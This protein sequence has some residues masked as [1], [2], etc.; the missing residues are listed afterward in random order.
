MLPAALAALAG[1]RFEPV[2]VVPVDGAPP[3]PDVSVDAPPPDANPDRDMDTILDEVDNC[4]NVANT[5]QDDCDGDD[6]GDACD[7]KADGPDADGDM[8]S[9]VCDNCP[10]VDN[11]DQ[12]DVRDA[13]EVG[14][15]CDPQP[16]QDGDTIAYFSGFDG[17]S[18]GQLPEGW[19]LASGT[20][21][22]DGRWRVED[23]KLV[24]D[25][26]DEPSILYLSGPTVPTDVI[27]EARFSVSSFVSG[28]SEPAF[29]GMLARYTNGLAIGGEDIGYLCQLEQGTGDPTATVRIEGLPDIEGGVDNAPWSGELDQSYTIKHNQIGMA[30]NGSISRCTVTPPDPLIAESVRV[31]DIPGPASGSIAL[32]TLRIGVAF[33]YIVVYGVGTAASAS[34]TAS[35]SAYHPAP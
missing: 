11:L 25:A 13:D 4:P 32:R 18:G 7:I 34:V 8:V 6:I 12:L 19:S 22:V 29:I 5:E 15:A 23:G 21:L 10:T 2:G 14:D 33:D 35:P 3:P 16:D 9:D 30:G 28:G 17:D 24:H 27:V 26:G 1:C 20:G 31:D